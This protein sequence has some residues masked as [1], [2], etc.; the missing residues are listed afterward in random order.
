MKGAERVTSAE[1]VYQAIKS[2]IFDRSFYPGEV[3]SE[4]RLSSELGV[5]RTPIRQALFRLYQE[6]LLERG[7][8]NAFRLT[9]LTKKDV[10][11]VFEVRE[12]LE[13]LTAR[14]AAERVKGDPRAK[15][16]VEALKAELLGLRD[17]FLAG[18]LKAEFQFDLKLHAT[19]MGLSGNTRIEA[20]INQM[21]A[22]IHHAR[23]RS[24]SDARTLETIDEHLAILQAVLEGDPDWAE[25]TMR[26]HVQKAQCAAAEIVDEE[27]PPALRDY[28]KALGG[29]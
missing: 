10:E 18:D 1:H 29:D 13:G 21:N 5:S 16:V 3:L 4:R 17:A 7:P 25:S 19:L 2:A 15:E 12:W 27:R 28:M 14:R 8:Q 26:R 22:Q 11:E 23:I 24:K 20:I 6:G 9:M